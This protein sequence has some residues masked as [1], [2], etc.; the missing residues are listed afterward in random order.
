MIS[1]PSLPLLLLT[2]FGTNPF[3]GRRHAGS[4]GIAPQAL[5]LP[6]GEVIIW[7]SLF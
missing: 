7:D 1:P 4:L 3:M 6:A 5:A 2:G